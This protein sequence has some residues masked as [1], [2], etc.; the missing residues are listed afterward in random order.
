MQADTICHL[1]MGTLYVHNTWPVLPVHLLGLTEKYQKQGFKWGETQ[2]GHQKSDP[3]VWPIWSSVKTVTVMVI[4]TC[5]IWTYHQSGPC[6]SCC[7]QQYVLLPSSSLRASLLLLSLAASVGKQLP[8]YSAFLLGGFSLL[9]SQSCLASSIFSSFYCW[10]LL[11]F[12]AHRIPLFFRGLVHLPTLPL[13]R[14]LLL[15]CVTE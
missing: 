7:P 1:R 4:L 15:H 13:L 3:L 11:F 6:L 12:V 14:E 9:A 2:A 8:S 10:F 5:L